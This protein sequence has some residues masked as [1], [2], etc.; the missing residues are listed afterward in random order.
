MQDDGQDTGTKLPYPLPNTFR[1][2]LTRH[3][4]LTERI[5]FSALSALVPCAPQDAQLQEIAA[6]YS[7]YSAWANEVLVSLA[8]AVVL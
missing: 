7:K 2:I 5:H 4:G 1:T 3:V 6:S 8:T